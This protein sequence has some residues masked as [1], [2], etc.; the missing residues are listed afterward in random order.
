M[1]ASAAEVLDR[2]MSVI[3]HSVDER[4][5][6]LVQSVISASFNNKGSLGLANTL[7][8]VQEQ[9]VQTLVISEGFGA[10]GSVCAHCGYL[11]LRSTDECPICGGEAREATDIVEHLVRRAIGHRRRSS[12]CRKRRVGQRRIHRR[13][14]AL[15]VVTP[16]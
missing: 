6:E 10:P 4:K 13:A 7:N 15:L 3:Q 14:V 9:R 5:A 1:Y 12:V 2:T 11:T 16:F 8:A